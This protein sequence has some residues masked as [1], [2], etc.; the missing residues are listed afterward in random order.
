MIPLLIAV[1]THMIKFKLNPYQYQTPQTRYIKL[2]TLTKNHSIFP[3]PKKHNHCDTEPS[4]T[5]IVSVQVL[6]GSDPL[7]FQ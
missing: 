2:L 7:Q 3:I 5:N 4:A 1:H 6:L